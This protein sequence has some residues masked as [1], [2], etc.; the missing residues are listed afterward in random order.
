[1][2]V[3]SSNNNLSPA[4]YQKALKTTFCGPALTTAL[5]LSA[6]VLKRGATTQG[7]ARH[8][9][10]ASHVAFTA[11]YASLLGLAVLAPV[12]TKPPANWGAGRPP[13]LF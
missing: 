6:L 7:L 2:S 1:M 12:V 13:R 5:G 3:Q 11:T 4:W 10:K 8:V 9:E